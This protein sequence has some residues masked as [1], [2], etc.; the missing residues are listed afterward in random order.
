METWF[1][2]PM[3]VRLITHS[4]Y[5]VTASSFASSYIYYRRA[6]LPGSQRFWLQWGCWCTSISH[7]RL[8]H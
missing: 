5:W 8:S 4:A 6:G 3:V 7:L 1:R 2:L